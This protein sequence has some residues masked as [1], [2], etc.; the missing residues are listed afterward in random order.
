MTR[1]DSDLLDQTLREGGR[2]F[3]TFAGSVAPPDA[4]QIARRAASLRRL[5]RV[6]RA[7]CVAAVILALVGLASV[8]GQRKETVELR[9]GAAERAEPASPTER[10]PGEHKETE[11]REVPLSELSFLRN[12]PGDPE[13]AAE[14]LPSGIKFLVFSWDDDERGPRRCAGVDNS[15]RGWGCSGARDPGDGEPNL[16]FDPE[17]APGAVVLWL[18]VPEETTIVE[19]ASGGAR[20]RQRPLDG[21]VAFPYS[22]NASKEFSLLAIDRDGEVIQEAR[23]S[24]QR[25][26]LGRCLPAL[27][28]EC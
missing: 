3:L 1:N 10:G 13:F 6:R 15:D 23:R 4:G 9:T 20:L 21:V 12:V 26:L 14:V 8:A 19:F 5:T 2:E 7:S 16:V 17:P 27:F 11:L 24:R 22:D 18:D 28:R 25:S